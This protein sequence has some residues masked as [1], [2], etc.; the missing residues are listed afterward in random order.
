MTMTL[1]IRGLHHVTSKSSDPRGTDR[2]WREVMGLRRVKQTVNFDNPKVYHL[3]FGNE[4]GEAGTVMTYFPFPNLDRGQRGTG[5]V[6]LVTFAV[7]H[8][9]LDLWEARLESAGAGDVMRDEAFGQAC[10]DFDA[11]D[12]DRFRLVEVEGD[13]RAPWPGSALGRQ[14]IRGFSGV[15]LT[16]AETGTTAEVL[17]AFGYRETASEGSVTRWTL[18]GH[19]GAGV[20][21]LDLRPD[22]P[23][24]VE[25]AGSVHHVAFA[26]ADR[27]A[28]D[29]V[30][31]AM[32]AA[33]HRVTH[34]YDRNYFYAIYFRT[35]GGVLFEVATHDPGF[36]ADEPLT[37]LGSALKLPPQHERMREML[38][39]S[40]VPLD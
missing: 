11:P 16:L 33:G 25:G 12:G 19:N 30:R 3:Y 21:D 14:A 29:R 34:V 37:T 2:F 32:L 24:A 17:E 10:L 36:D 38:E 8:G 23:K 35:P 7:P 13:A 6:S 28:Q 4:A 1:P 31:E 20:V 18:P 15:T 27:A 26:V 5:E 40:L 22:L 39:D 9:V